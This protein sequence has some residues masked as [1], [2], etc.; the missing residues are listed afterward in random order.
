[1]TPV[2]STTLGRLSGLDFDPVSGVLYASSGGGGPNPDSL[3]TVDPTSGAATLIGPFNAERSTDLGID[4]DGTIF[5]T[6]FA[7]LL[8]IDPITGNAE[9]VGSFGNNFIEAIDVDPTTGTLHGLTFN[10]G[11]FFSIDKTTGFATMLGSY[12]VP[13]HDWTGLG[14]DHSGNVFASTGGRGSATAGD[15]YLLNPNFTLTFLG[16]HGSAVSDITFRP[17]ADVPEPG[18]LALF[19]L[20]LAALGYMRRRRAA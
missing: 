18:T 15:I 14:I 10:N 2:G 11:D 6:N 12:G 17:P 20:G 8:I 3:F 9:P 1:M 16:T 19:G 13:G 7:G 4:N 5:A